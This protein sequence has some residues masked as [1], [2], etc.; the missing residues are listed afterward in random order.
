MQNIISGGSQVSALAFGSQL[1]L[2]SVPVLGVDTGAAGLL[3]VVAFV[4][5]VLLLQALHQHRLLNLLLPLVEVVRGHFLGRHHREVVGLPLRNSL[6]L[7][8]RLLGLLRPE[9]L[10]RLPEPP[11]LGQLPVLLGEL[12]AKALRLGLPA[13][14]RGRRYISFG[15][16]FRF[17]EIAGAF[18]IFGSV[19][20]FAGLAD[21]D[22]AFFDFAKVKLLAAIAGVR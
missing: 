20:I 18:P 2:N 16:F 10:R 7:D 9:L 14:P 4:K 6:R 11:R 22:F 19:C 5:P 13:P 12:P 8:V 21:I 1:T 17:G 3:V 15:A